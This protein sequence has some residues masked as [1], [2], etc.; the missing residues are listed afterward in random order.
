MKRYGSIALVIYL[1]LLFS[2]LPAGAATEYTPAPGISTS[3]GHPVSG[4]FVIADQD[5]DTVNPAIAYNTIFEQYLVV[6]YNDRPGYDDIYAQLLDKYGNKIGNWRAPAAGAGAERRNP[7]VYFNPNFNEYLIVWEHIDEATGAYSIRGQ[8][9]NYNVD[10][11]GGEIIIGTPTTSGGTAM[12]PKVAHAFTSGKYLVVWQNHTQ[13]SLT[14]DI[15]GRL[16]INNGTLDGPSFTISQGTTNFIMETPDLAYNRRRNEFLVVWDQLD[17]G[18][19][20]Y[21]VYARIVRPDKTMPPDKIE[22]SR[23]TA[24]STAPS[25]GALPLQSSD[26]QYL[27]AFEVDYGGGDRNVIGRM[28]NGDGTLAPQSFFIGG[29]GEDDYNPSV[30][31]NEHLNQYL[32]TWTRPT[33]GQ[34]L[35]EYI[36]GRAFSTAG[37]AQSDEI[38]MGGVF[39]DHSDTIAGP[40]GD[41][42]TVFDDLTLGIN[43]DV[44]GRFWGNRIY[45]PMTLQEAH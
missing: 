1:A 26:G 25:V 27:V 45:L 11:Q 35:F 37:I 33:G 28:I 5:I 15:W 34:L 24:S 22:I 30:A 4:P 16:V 10:K 18:A 13:A 40:L 41:Y 39:P 7:D 31:G 3:G 6:W 23:L 36:A 12:K 38:F 14:N 8:R 43:R 9:V 17:S 42:L 19:G 21:D 29:S 44:Y 20:L 2:Y 32:V